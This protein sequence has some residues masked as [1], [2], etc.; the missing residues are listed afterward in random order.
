MSLR[1]LLVLAL[2]MPFVAPHATAS[3]DAWVLEDPAG[4]AG[5]SLIGGLPSA[6]IPTTAHV[7]LRSITIDE[8]D[9]SGFALTIHV[10]H[11]AAPKPTNL[12]A[13]YVN[14]NVQFQV[15]GSEARYYLGVHN[16]GEFVADA[17]SSF[18]PSPFAGGYLSACDNESCFGQDLA[19]EQVENGYRIWV[20]KGALVG[21]GWDP[22]YAPPSLPKSIDQGSSLTKIR[23]SAYGSLVPLFSSVRD[24]APNTD[25]APPYV[26]KRA[27][28]NTVVAL[29][30]HDAYP[31]LSV[32][33]GF[34]QSLPLVVVNKGDAKRLL[35]FSYAVEGPA[36]KVG[37][38]A[39][40]GPPSMAIPAQSTRNFTFALNVQ[41]GASAADGVRLVVRSKSLGHA[42]EV[43]VASALLSPGAALT[44]E[45]N[46]LH[47]FARPANGFVPQPLCDVPNF[48]FICRTGFVSPDAED[49]EGDA[50]AAIQGYAYPA[51]VVSAQQYF[52][53]P[54]QRGLSAPIAF[55]R[56][57]PTEI[58]LV[59]RSQTPAEGLRLKAELSWA[60]SDFEDTMAQG[61]QTV[62]VGTSPTSVKL[63]LPTMLQTDYV[64]RGT[65]LGLRIDVT[66]EA[67]TTGYPNWALG[68]LEI[69][70]KDSLI[71]LPIAPLPESLRPD[72]LSN[73]FQ[74]TPVDE[75]GRE[76]FVNPGE[77]R[78]FN[79]SLLHQGV[80]EARVHLDAVVA[81]AGWTVEVLPGSDYNMKPG[82][83][84][85][86]GVLAHA[87]PDARE[88]ERADIRLN[89][90]DASGKPVTLLLNAIITSGIDLHDDSQAFK[91]DDEALSKLAVDKHGTPGFEL[92]LLAVALVGFA[93]RR[94]K[95]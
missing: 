15:A 1:P 95:A 20:P 84:L 14:F 18:V 10:G 68:G 72:A 12:G 34:N 39:V 27:M 70:P 24:V 25:F 77:G 67:T 40:Y 9:E 49:P 69:L 85:T 13:N 71:R 44:P 81:P 45:Q 58:E 82:D 90:T 30:L 93:L 61:G 57:K 21:E 73:P 41:P 54:M 4:D 50:D 28:G 56:T 78:L 33:S 32:Q 42:D 66:Y 11:L 23:V 75:D 6:P 88:A 76:E 92:W 43:G 16:S 74:L 3:P 31:S 2:L 87:P 7:D 53:L 48:L 59:L 51:S 38:Y 47:F 22:D 37:R 79:V 80:E 63:A 8:E 36:D 26:F 91:A 46:T 35:Q 94:R 19:V 86:L 55:D 17:E 29:Q 5:P 89:A 60:G 62:N 64:P 83:A 65:Q 52:F